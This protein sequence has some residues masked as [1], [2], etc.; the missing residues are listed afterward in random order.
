MPG[1][2]PFHAIAEAAATAAIEGNVDPSEVQTSTIS[3]AQMRDWHSKTHPRDLIGAAHSVVYFVAASVA[4][5]RFDWEHMTAAKMTDP[6]ITQLQDKVIFDPHP[7]PLPDRFTH[8]HGG[9]VIIQMKSGAIHK[10]TCVSARGSGMRG[11]DWADVDHKYHQLMPLSNLSD[12][13]IKDSLSVIHEFEKIKTAD[14][15]TSLLK[16]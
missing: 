13:K 16:V 10:S 6:L 12:Q 11:I 15:L 9:T 4:D 1:G 8:R 14:Q 2:H 3:A 7:T 5:R